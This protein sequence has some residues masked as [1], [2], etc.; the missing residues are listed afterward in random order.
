[1]QKLLI[2]LYRIDFSLDLA[3]QYGEV[4]YEKTKNIIICNFITYDEFVFRNNCRSR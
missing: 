1:M 4:S 2:K 3:D